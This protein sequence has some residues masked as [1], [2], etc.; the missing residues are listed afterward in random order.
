MLRI[1]EVA[2]QRGLSLSRFQIA[3]GMPLSSARRYWHS[4]ATGS[5]GG[6]GSL[7]QVDLQTLEHIA[8]VL[9]CEVFELFKTDVR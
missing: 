5:A 8:N 4:S 2:R 7:R 3:A 9:Q 1:D 6:R